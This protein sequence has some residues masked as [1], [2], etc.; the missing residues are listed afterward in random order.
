MEEKE[1]LRRQ[2]RLLQGEGGRGRGLC[3][4]VFCDRRR[5]SLKRALSVAV[6]GRSAWVGVGAAASGAARGVTDLPGFGA[7]ERAG[8]VDWASEG[9]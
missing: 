2:I 3:P 8:R 7:T 4:L 5:P 6:S 9:W 1:Q